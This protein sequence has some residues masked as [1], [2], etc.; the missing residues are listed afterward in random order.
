MSTTLTEDQEMMVEAA[1]EYARGELLELDRSWDEDETSMATVLPQL[2]EMGFMNLVASEELGGLACS[3]RLYADILHEI[4]Y[5]SP[6]VA[7]GLS[8]HNMVG[9]ILEQHAAEPKRT[10]WLSQWGKAESFGAFSVSEAGAGSDPSACTTEAKRVDGGY[11]V[12]GEKMWITNGLA[13]R[14]FMTLV[15][16]DSQAGK[17]G[18]SAVL[19]DGNAQGLERDKI[20]GKMGIRG[21]ET[22]VIHYDDVFVPESHLLGAEGEGL[23]VC[24]AALDG[25]RI[26]IGSQATGI[27]QACLDEMV[28]YATQREQFGRPIANF[29]AIQIMIADSATE[30]SAARAL[31]HTA[32]DLVDAGRIDS[33]ASAKAKLFASEAANRIAYWAIQVHGGTGY[34]KECRVEQLARDARVTTIYEGTSE[35]QR[36]VIARELLR[37]SG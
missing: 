16:T 27:A 22:A 36:I 26:G 13:G 31:I 35:I 23:K 19:V 4:A 32:A 9:S 12:S 7:V 5:A 10:E 33:A 6:S 18:L 20:R 11:R 1:R 15:R 34:V 8:V 2:A 3:Y 30:L 24:L 29:Q 21:S 25:G 14:W 17:A 28:S 37:N